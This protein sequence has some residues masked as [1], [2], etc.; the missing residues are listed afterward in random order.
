MTVLI[1]EANSELRRVSLDRH[2]LLHL[3]I[4]PKHIGVGFQRQPL[5]N[6]NRRKGVD[7][8]IG[9]KSGDDNPE[10][11]QRQHKQ[12]HPGGCVPDAV[13]SPAVGADAARDH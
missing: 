10:G 12:N 7:L 1:P 9:A 11:W 2:A 5:R 6:P 3:W 13:V 4:Q 8:D